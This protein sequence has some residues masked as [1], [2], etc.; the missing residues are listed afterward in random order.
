M[1]GF[2]SRGSMS[3]RMN[4][5]P[6]NTLQDIKSMHLAVRKLE[7]DR[8]EKDN[9]KIAKKIFLME[10]AFKINDLREEFKQHVYLSGNV[11]KIKREVLP[12][13][14]SARQQ[15]SDKRKQILKKKR[16]SRAS[17]MDS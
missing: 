12:Q 15:A 1:N 3:T 4:I 8:I 13:I 10:P 9:I 16:E 17:K 2:N 5:N 6:S 14:M 11:N 7:M